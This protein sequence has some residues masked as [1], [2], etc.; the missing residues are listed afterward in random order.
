MNVAPL[1]EA[2]GKFCL[3]LHEKIYPHPFLSQQA[4]RWLPKTMKPD[5]LL[6][7]L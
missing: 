3:W 4:G 7:N 6:K 2:W 1:L 5:D